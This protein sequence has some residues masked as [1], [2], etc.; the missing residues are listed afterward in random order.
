MKNINILLKRICAYIV[1][2]IIVMFISILI[3]SIPY[4]SKDNEKYQQKYSEYVEEYNKYIE[5]KTLLE[6]TYD[7]ET[8]T[9]EEYNKLLEK[10]MY[11]EKIISSYE[12]N[13]ISKGEYKNILELYEKDFTKMS[14]DYNYKLGKLSYQDTLIILLCTLFYFAIVQYLLK[15][16]T[17]GKK[18]FKIKVVSINKN[19]VSIINYIIRSLIVNNVFLN[20]LGIVFLLLTPKQ[21][22]LTLNNILSILIS[23]TE[24]IIIYLVLT[25]DDSRGLHDL[26]VKTKVISLDKENESSNK[27]IEIEETKEVKNIETRKKQKGKSRKK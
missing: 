15:G 16:Q 3:S 13:Q 20:L 2:I 18:L 23:L 17:I 25:R 19:K 22:Y 27:I 4:I 9:K 7:D 1:D 5:F 10:E 6:E 24:G 21:T 26:L 12:D 8:I 11:T 14:E